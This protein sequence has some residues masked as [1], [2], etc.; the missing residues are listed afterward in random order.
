MT[1]HNLKKESKHE[2]GW[3]GKSVYRWA[4]N[5]RMKSVWFKTPE[6]RDRAAQRHLDK[7]RNSE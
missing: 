5:C 2:G 6:G 1:D 3:H 7:Y 4:C